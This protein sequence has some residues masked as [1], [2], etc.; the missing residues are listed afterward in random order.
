MK[1]HC[2]TCRDRGSEYPYKRS[3]PQ[4]YCTKCGELMTVLRKGSIEHCP[5]CGRPYQDVSI[6]CPRK[7]TF[8]SGLT[9]Q[10]HDSKIINFVLL[11]KKP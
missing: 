6:E 3:N 10:Y 9:L 11:P 5:E 4:A 8:W 7:N 2:N 1:N